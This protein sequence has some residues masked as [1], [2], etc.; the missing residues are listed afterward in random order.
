MQENQLDEMKAAKP[1][2]AEEQMK[3][4]IDALTVVTDNDVSVAM[5]SNVVRSHMERTGNILMSK[6]FHMVEKFDDLITPIVL[7]DLSEL[8]DDSRWLLFDTAYTRKSTELMGIAI[9]CIE[10]AKACK[11]Q[12]ALENQQA[13]L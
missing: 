4:A 12:I 7:L 13:K 6:A 2:S 5:R 1:I 9:A 10:N 11:I 3:A 8:G